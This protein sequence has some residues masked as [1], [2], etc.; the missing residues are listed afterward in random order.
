MFT[1]TG[2]I[3]TMTMHWVFD[4]PQRFIT[5]SACEHTVY[6]PDGHNNDGRWNISNIHWY[7]RNAQ[8]WYGR[9]VSWQAHG[10]DD[11]PNRYVYPIGAFSGPT[12]W[13]GLPGNVWGHPS[14]FEIIPAVVLEDARQGKV[15]LLIDNLNEGF[16][17]PMLWCFLH[18]ECS[19]LGLNPRCLAY[20]HS[21]TKDEQAYNIWCDDLGISDRFHDI[22]F[23]HLMYQQRVALPTY[24]TVSWEQQL[25]HKS[26]NLDSIRIYNCLNRRSHRHREYLFLRLLEMDL[27]KHGLVSCDKLVW[28]WTDSDIK[29]MTMVRAQGL[30]PIVVDDHDFHNNKAM[31]GNPDIY[32]NSWLSVITE[33]HANDDP[34]HLF[35]SEKVWKPIYFMQPFMTLGNLGCDQQLREWG[36]QTYWDMDDL[37]FDS[38][39]SQICLELKR[40]RQMSQ[41]QLMD[42]YQR[43]EEKCQHNKTLFMKQDFFDSPA[44]DRIVTAYAGLLPC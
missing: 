39:V 35:V 15:L 27:V 26:H 40:M 8:Q 13:S 10:L 17:M 32:L 36:Y 3:Q 7:W 5:M 1:R 18:S 4:D 37:S 41:N 23:C 42:W 19:R 31:H 38:K 9:D 28:D 6:S 33:T 21:N 43:L 22:G 44:A 12:W 30:L 20:V 11:R 25:S 16:H 24:G 2:E 34:Y 14:M 29:P